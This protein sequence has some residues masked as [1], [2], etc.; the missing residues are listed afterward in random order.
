MPNISDFFYCSPQKE[1]YHALH[2]TPH[3][4]FY[5]PFS[6]LGRLS[7]AVWVPLHTVGVIIKPCFY[8]CLAVANL[9]RSFVWFPIGFLLKETELPSFYLKRGGCFLITAFVS[10][11]SQFLQIFK[12][13]AGVLHPGVYYKSKDI[14]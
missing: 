6:S 11:L 7:C 5:K 12:A 2:R 9:A 8:T 10:P 4:S 14:S 13:A 1:F 3:S